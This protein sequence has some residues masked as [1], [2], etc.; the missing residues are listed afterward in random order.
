[1]IRGV[2]EQLGNLIK[3]VSAWKPPMKPVITI[4]C[5]CMKNKE[6]I[7]A[8]FRL[9]HSGAIQYLNNVCKGCDDK[10]KDY[11]TII[12]CRC[13]TA[14]ARME[15]HEDPS[16]FIFRR[17]ATYHTEQCGVCT[18]SIDR[19]VLIEK[20]LWDDSRRRVKTSVEFSPNR[21]K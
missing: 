20:K 10:W 6:P 4:P 17:G 21:R 8:G 3:T 19:S 13:K 16:G 1:M 2:D 9:K 14:V 5:A 12:C 18:E 15:P 11:C 7:S